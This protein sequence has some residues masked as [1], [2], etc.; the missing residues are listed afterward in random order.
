[1]YWRILSCFN[2]KQT[3]HFRL[4]AHQLRRAK[5]KVVLAVIAHRETQI[6]PP[7]FGKVIS[8]HNVQQAALPGYIELINLQGDFKALTRVG[9]FN[10]SAAAFRDQPAAEWIFGSRPGRGEVACNLGLMEISG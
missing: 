1:M 9:I 4:V 2:R 6:N 7:A 8:Q 3:L 5:C 10:D